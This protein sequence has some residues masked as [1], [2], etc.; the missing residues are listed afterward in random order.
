M[1]FE[2]VTIWLLI[3]MGLLVV[4]F[5]V[6]VPSFMVAEALG[7][8][9]IAV[10]L[11]AWFVPG[12]VWLQVLTWVILSAGGIWYSRRFIPKDSAALK[13]ATEAVTLTEIAPGQCGRVEYEGV[14]WQAR[15]EDV[16]TA[17]PPNH[18]VIVVRR[19]GNTLIVVPEQWVLER[20]GVE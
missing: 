5:M 14:S 12:L 9:A 17:I 6:P 15:C 2:P 13:D 7:F 8:C 11:L 16:Q 3:G 10:S 1:V 18:N 20:G 4:E 19:Q